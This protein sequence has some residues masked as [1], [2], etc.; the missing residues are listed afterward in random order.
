M[1]VFGWF[2]FTLKSP[3]TVAHWDISLAIY[4]TSIA[5]LCQGPPKAGGNQFLYPRG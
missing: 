5:I 2:K 3:D 4:V 1:A